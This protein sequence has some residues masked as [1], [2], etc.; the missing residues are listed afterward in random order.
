VIVLDTNVISELMRPNPDAN[1]LTWVA[2]VSRALLHT[3]HIN[4]AEILYGIAALPEGRRRT[5]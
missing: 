1:V 5:A 3:T 4:Q 2:K